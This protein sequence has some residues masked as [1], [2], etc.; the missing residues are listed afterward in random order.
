[1]FIFDVYFLSFVCLFVY[2]DTQQN[3][4]HERKFGLKN[5]LQL[6]GPG[7]DSFPWNEWSKKEGFVLFYSLCVE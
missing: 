3:E 7:P 1:M 2:F 6:A 4:A 5:S